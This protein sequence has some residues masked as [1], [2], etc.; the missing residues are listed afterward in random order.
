MSEII[1]TMDADAFNLIANHPDVRPWMLGEGEIDV[2]SALA[3]PNNIGLLSAHG[4]FVLIKL[5]DGFYE[6]HTLFHPERGGPDAMNAARGG[7]RYL[8]TAT[9]CIEVVTKVPAENKRALG[10]ARNLNLREVERHD[11]SEVVPFAYSR[12]SLTLDRWRALDSTLEAVGFEFHAALESA[13]IEAGSPLEVHA[14]DAAHER[15][16]GASIL[17]AR[18]GNP[19]KAVVQY[20]RWAAFAGYAPIRLIS[21]APVII[22]VVDAIVTLATGGRM[23]VLKCHS[24]RQ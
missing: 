16:V 22:D 9:D 20:N 19:A 7:F 24:A 5:A 18:A 6:A 4:G 3:N 11:A 12:F 17:M 23:E 2:S 14:H 10:F 15:A 1:R 8:F 21:V 13:K